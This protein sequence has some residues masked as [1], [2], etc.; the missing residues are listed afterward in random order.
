MA[1]NIP[2]WSAPEKY[3]NIRAP[4]SGH[5]WRL[6]DCEWRGRR[7]H[8][9]VKPVQIDGRRDSRERISPTQEAS[10]YTPPS[11]LALARCM[12]PRHNQE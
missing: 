4:P 12:S 1:P 9:L 5:V 7:E 10:I 3:A 2:P 8:P 11:L 6:R